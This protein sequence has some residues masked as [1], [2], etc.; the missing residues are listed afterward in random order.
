MLALREIQ[1]LRAKLLLD[2]QERS[3]HQAKTQ[4]L[5]DHRDLR[6]KVLLDHQEKLVHQDKTQLLL[7]L[8][9]N[10]DLQVTALQ[11]NRDPQVLHPK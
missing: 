8:R 2:H 9:E 11:E 3:A 5:L 6:A 7:D 4:V 10:Q 1:V